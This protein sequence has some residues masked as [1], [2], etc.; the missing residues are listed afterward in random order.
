[1]T[2]LEETGSTPEVAVRGTYVEAGS[3]AGERGRI[4]PLTEGK[5]YSERMVRET[6][7]RGSWKPA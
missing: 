7:F 2:I 6:T 3:T 4:E 5:N 1:M